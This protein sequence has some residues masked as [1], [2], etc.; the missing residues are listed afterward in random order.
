MAK[1][2]RF[3]LHATDL[4]F[5]LKFKHA[6]SSRDTSSSLF[7]KCTLDN[8]VSGWGEALP[9]PYVTGETR[10]DA[11]TL[12]A[13]K[14]LPRLVGQNFDNFA[15]VRSFLT[16][17]DG[18][19][20]T[21]WVPAETPSSAAWCAVDLA[22]L[23]TFGKQFDCGP[24]PD[25]SG[26]LP[27]DF[28]YSGVLTSGSGLKRTLQLLAYRFLGYRALK[29]KVD[30]NTSEADL[31]A[32]RRL[33]GKIALRADANMAWSV[34]DAL[35]HMPLEAKHGVASFEQP[36]AADDLDG[37]A[38]LVTETGLDVM[39]D[40][41]LNTRESLARLIESKACTAINARISKCGGLVATLRRCRE[42]V[43]AGLWVQVGCQV[44]ES[45]LLSAAHLHLCHTFGKMRHAEGCFGKLLLNEDPVSPLLQMTRG[46]RPPACP[47]GPGLGVS[48]SEE[49]LTPHV[50]RHWSVTSPD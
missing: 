36:L 5:R 14:I 23:D 22:L 13:D 18:T 47:A 41:S 12:L 33:S 15:T 8:G 49:Q 1:I 3:D 21:D 35:Q 31:R 44:G 40:E 16:D 45:S 24:Y 27:P 7:L 34:E 38:R 43:D 25:E 30:R 10:D 20:P 9:R 11:C 48:V 2:A 17:C 37:A 39:A 4:P 6:A 29:L 26:T 42:A 50:T 28:R 46:G 32:V 19:P